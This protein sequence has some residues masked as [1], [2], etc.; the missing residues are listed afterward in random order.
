MDRIDKIIYEEAQNTAYEKQCEQGFTHQEQ[1]NED[2]FEC[3]NDYLN[4]TM[5]V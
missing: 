1:P 4:G 5:S 2:Y 3:V